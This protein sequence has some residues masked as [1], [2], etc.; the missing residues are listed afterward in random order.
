MSPAGLCWQG[1]AAIVN[2]RPIL[3]SE[4]V[5]RKDYNPQVFIWIIKLLVMSLEELVAKTN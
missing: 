2:D 5:L 4:R 3:S 1:Q